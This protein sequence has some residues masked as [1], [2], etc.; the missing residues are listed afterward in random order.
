M[1]WLFWGGVAFLAY[2]SVGYPFLLWVLSLFRNRKHR[3][4]PIWPSVSLIIPAHNEGEQIRRKVLNTLELTYP[5]DKR[6]ILV[7]SDGSNDD[8]VS[9]VRGYAEEGVKLV[10]IPEKHGKHYAQ[11]IARDRSQGEILVFTDV[12]AILECNALEKI[13]SNFADPSIGCISSEDQVLA[14]GGRQGGEVSYIQ[15]DKWMRRLES[16]VGSLVSL[17]GSFFA[18]RREVCAQWNPVQSSDFFLALQAVSQGFRAVVDP[19]CWSHYSLTYPERVEFAR[20]V[21]T[22]VHGLDVVFSNW[23]LLNPFR[24]GFFSWQLLSHKLFRWLAPFAFLSIVIS[25]LF[26]WDAGW[27]YRLVLVALLCL[28]GCGLLAW[29]S[30]RASEVKPL[31]LAAYFLLGNVAAMYAWFKYCSGER[32]A[33]WEPTPRR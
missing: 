13:V 28:Y 17:S 30:D 32:F 33:T 25:G 22:M 11:M 20:K 16:Q 31:R 5:P 3:R 18:A 23:K 4:A 7:A 15:Y 14:T 29:S 12:S 19:E 2:T 10:E 6:E 1:V 8:T 9:I 27:F 26:L 24:Y 21:R